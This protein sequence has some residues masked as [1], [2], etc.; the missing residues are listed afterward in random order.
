MLRI[1]NLS[2]VNLFMVL[3]R[4]GGEDSG[5]SGVLQS[6]PQALEQN[7]PSLVHADTLDHLSA[8]NP[9]PRIRP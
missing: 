8:P 1:N 6:L 7:P 3:L 2:A 5:D 4:T 9:R